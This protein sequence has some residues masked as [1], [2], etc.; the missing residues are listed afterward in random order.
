MTVMKL[1]D[2]KKY[3]LKG[4]SIKTSSSTLWSADNPAQGQCAVTALIVQDYLGGEIFKTYALT[5]SGKV[6][7]YYNC[8]GGKEV[9][10]TRDQFA[11]DTM[12][13]GKIVNLPGYDS[14]REYCLSFID[15]R[16]RYE[17]LKEAVHSYA[18]RS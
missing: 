7:H 15:T 5:P 14:L 8:I 18:T 17:L 1:E 4:W 12:F 16:R 9:D 2:L 13:E 11:I 3:L 6:S 10:L